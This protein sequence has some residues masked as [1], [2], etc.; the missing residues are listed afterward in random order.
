MGGLSFGNGYFVANSS[1][2]A[3]GCVRSQDG[4]TW[5]F[6][7]TTNGASKAAEFVMNRHI[8]TTTTAGVSNSYASFDGTAWSPV[9][10]QQGAYNQIAVVGSRLIGVG[11]G[12]NATASL[13]VL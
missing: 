6:F 12:Q 5:D 13:E 8:M 3:T 2:G 4:M 1:S 10:N 7:P 9:P 11:Y